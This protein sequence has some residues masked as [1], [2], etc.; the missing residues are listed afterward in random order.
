MVG[1]L[2]ALDSRLGQKP[3]STR[4]S[5]QWSKRTLLSPLVPETMTK[6]RD[7]QSI[8]IG[9]AP[10]AEP[11]IDAPAV[12]LR[13][14]KKAK[15]D[16]PWRATA[17]P[18]AIW[19][20]EV[21]LQ[22]TRVEV[23]Q[24]YYSAWMERFPDISALAK[25]K[26]AD[27]LRVWQGLGYYSRARR[28][29]EGAVFIVR[30][31]GGVV[32]D[33]QD[34]LQKIPGIGPYSAGAIG[35]IAFGHRVP[36]IDGNVVRVTCRYWALAGDPTR[37]P[38]KRVI[39]ERVT[40]WLPR[41]GVGDFN[42]AL[43]ELGA[44]ICLPR[45]P[46]CPTCPIR[47]GCQAFASG[48]TSHL[49]TRKEKAK[50]TRVRA[51]P[52]LWTERGRMLVL[53][54][55][56]DA[57]WWAGLTVLPTLELGDGSGG[58]LE[59][60]SLGLGL[61]EGAEAPEE[62]AAWMQRSL[63]TSADVRLLESIAHT[64]TRHRLELVPTVIRS[65]AGGFATLGGPRGRAATLAWLRPTEIAEEPLGAPFRRIVESYFDKRT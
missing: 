59:P 14:F 16:L 43:M 1:C 63:G 34:N 62:V 37:A 32:P 46:L 6:V 11:R 38:L 39:A 52:L 42:Q 26:R 5:S 47:A 36:A 51:V 45:A 44:T 35:S 58:A 56:P 64:V 27:V 54:L 49:P 4:A 20:S 31:H 53:R 15:R 10:V 41:S 17:D 12:L 28:L 65:P 7:L 23:V 40:E 24:R 30:E 13:W 25:A 18:Y 22:Q 19:V 21:M 57:R 55:G 8:E 2:L 61:D 9:T 33:E 50:P 3:G 29:Q 60:L 48:L